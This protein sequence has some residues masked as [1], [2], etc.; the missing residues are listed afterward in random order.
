MP[1]IK[2]RLI[3]YFGVVL[4]LAGAAYGYQWLK[5]RPTRIGAQKAIDEIVSQH[6]TLESFG[7]LELDA[8]TLTFGKLEE[9]LQKPAKHLGVAVSRTWWPTRTSISSLPNRLPESRRT[10]NLIVM[11]SAGMC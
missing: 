10:K 3:F 9:R 8:S 6:K 4:I 11:V 2:K 5:F 7:D 1:Q